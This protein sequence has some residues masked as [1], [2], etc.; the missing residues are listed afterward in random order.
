MIRA[1]TSCLWFFAALALG[2]EAAAQ[3]CDI[4]VEMEH[5]TAHDL[6]ADMPC[7]DNMATMPHDPDPAPEHDRQT[8]CCAA[9][10]GNGMTSAAPELG[11]PK[12]GL[13][14]WATPMPDN[15]NSVFLDYEP[16]PPR[17]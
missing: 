4:L 6:A 8:C 17:A 11:Q 3:P 13:T 9:L 14:L 5:E 12:P 2:F 7:H 15:A 1:L 16:P 10:L